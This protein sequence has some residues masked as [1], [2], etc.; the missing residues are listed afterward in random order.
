MVVMRVGYSSMPSPTDSGVLSAV[1]AM[2]GTP[3]KAGRGEPVKLKA[4]YIWP[5]YG[6]HDELCVAF[7]EARRP[8]H[9]EQAL[10]LSR[11]THPSTMDDGEGCR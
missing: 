6:E 7:F 11:G 8:E 4:A 3:I 9:V 2:V 10:R 5:V 1:K